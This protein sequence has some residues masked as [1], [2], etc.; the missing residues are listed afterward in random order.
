MSQ[1]TLPA[2]K[3]SSATMTNNACKA[4]CDEQGYTI[5]ATQWSEVGLA[6]STK[7]IVDDSLAL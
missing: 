5:A 4:I 6:L 1:R 7:L 2:F 3:T